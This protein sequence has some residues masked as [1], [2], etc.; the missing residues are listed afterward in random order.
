MNDQSRCVAGCPHSPLEHRDSVRATVCWS[1][2]CPLDISGESALV[3]S[4]EG[5]SP[6][7]RDELTDDS[8]E[9][10]GTEWVA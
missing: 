7:A 8:P 9:L 5:S 6:L 3:V 1:A 2:H 10:L 4:E